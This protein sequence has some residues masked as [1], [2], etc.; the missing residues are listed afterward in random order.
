MPRLVCILNK[1]PLPTNLLPL[2][3]QGTGNTGVN[4]THTLCPRGA[5]SLV[6]QHLK[7]VIA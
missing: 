6:K 2:T 1:Y 4:Y 3:L 7:Q 5:C